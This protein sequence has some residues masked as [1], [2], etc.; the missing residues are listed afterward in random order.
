MN[1]LTLSR[2]KAA[3]GVF[4]VKEGWRIFRLAPV[5]WMGMT[6]FAFMVILAVSLIPW[7]GQYIIELLSPFLVAGYFSA[8]RAAVAGEPVTFLHLG[9]GVHRGRIALL[10]I[11]M[12]YLAGSLIIFG[13]IHLFTGSDVRALMQQAQDPGSLSPEAFNRLIGSVLPGMLLAMVML[14]L[15][16]MATWF[17]PGLALF[18][19]F[20]AGQALWWSLWACWVNWRPVLYYSLILGLLGAVA[21]AIPFGLGLL[22]FLPLALIS[23]HVAYRMIFIP[24][25]TSQMESAEL[26]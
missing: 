8:S 1:A 6:A 4:W 25:Q 19:D 3:A 26:P 22:V 2:P 24:A 12:F 9:A 14:T 13:L 15:L 17:S 7:I 5:P 21:L 20:P 10:R 16:L 18:E 23:T 11:G